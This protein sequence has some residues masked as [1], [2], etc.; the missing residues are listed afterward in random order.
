MGN[1]YIVHRIFTFVFLPLLLLCWA[2]NITYHPQYSHHAEN[3][4]NALAILTYT[5]FL[6]NITFY[7]LLTK[8]SFLFCSVACLQ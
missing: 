3:V 2:K 8:N 7:E 5:S 6:Y 1:I 4:Y